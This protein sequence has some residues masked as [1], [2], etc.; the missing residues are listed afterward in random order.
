MATFLSLI[1]RFSARHRLVV[2]GAWL[3]I[4]VGLIGTL[5]VASGQGS[6]GTASTSI[7]S[8]QSSQALERMSQEFPDLGTSTPSSLQLV[9]QSDTG[10]AVTGAAATAQ[11]AGVLADA[12]TIPDIASVSDPFD[13]QKPYIS[14]DGSTAVSTLSFGDLSADQQKASYEAA[15][16]MQAD[17]PD[18]LRVEVGGNLVPLGAPPAGIGEGVGVIVAFL[19]LILTFGSLLA[20]GVNLLIAV[21]GVGVG[22]VG[23]LA[24]GA[25]TPIGD[26]TI[27]LAPMLG[28]A[29]GIDYSLFILTRFRAELRSGRN[30]EDS[31]AR[32]TGTAGSS[33]VFAGLTVIIALVGLLVANISFITEMG[34]AAAF[35][36][37]VS[38]LMA[39][40]LLPV[41][42]RTL[43]RRVLPKKQRTRRS[44][45]F[46]TPSDG[47]TDAQSPTRKGFLRR[48]GTFV[49]AHPVRS[50]LAGV[51]VLVIV[52]APILSMKTA[53][54][55]PGGADPTSTQRTAYN[56][57]IDE[58]GGVQSPLVV[59]AEADGD[60]TAQTASVQ[61]A[62]ASLPGVQMVV[63]GPIS[64]DGNV[65][66][67][68][69][70]P[71]EGPIDQQTKD[72][73]QQI[74]TDADSVPGI[75]LE[76][77]GETAI[78]IDQDQAL[79]DALI[80]YL[81]VIVVISLVLL[82][83][84]F[85]SLLIPLIATL[86]YLLSVGASFGASVAVFQWGW[87]DPLIPAPQGDPMMSILPILLVG[88]LFGL[89][90]D[91]QVFLVSRIQEMHNTGMS[92]KQAIIEGF[93]RSGPVL[94]A[95]ATI[96]TVV[97]AGFAT[98]T[99]PIAASIAFGLVVGVM[100]D[101]FIVRLILM[102][103]MMSLLGKAA[104]WLPKWLDRLLPNLDM[105]G[106][107]L[108]ERPDSQP[109]K[110]EAVLVTE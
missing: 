29:V 56:L 102:P 18:G 55:I 43:G 88:V 15:L 40:T 36:I 62:L 39:L 46:G 75:H 54:S 37:L 61:D 68:T 104:W 76:V 98:S 83:V 50:L 19:V 59:L 60:I 73:V 25:L 64:A 109:D 14:Q 71:A 84:M 65:A 99:F 107:A 91:Y 32:A 92:P 100:A 101:A 69:V 24:Y 38:V 81:I 2:V 74:R 34:I 28:L 12:A 27:I 41:L 86:G 45:A 16:T 82:I 9:F 67:L 58:F 72:L 31:V 5:V 90:M 6:P 21:F 94:V 4:F 106:H 77:T 1:G 89:A 48:W 35:A 53:F 97:F 95:A 23:V 96:M 47:S 33:V 78:G 8:T 20:A 26:T 63:P 51:V 52:A 103:A 7:P 79:Q 10:A 44:N 13:A 22:L 110:R 70:I 30:V 85:R 80:R 11:I 66:L 3:L 17:A 42:M 93:S 57:I 105:E 49:V 108:D 87:L